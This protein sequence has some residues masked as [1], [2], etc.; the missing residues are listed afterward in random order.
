MRVHRCVFV[1]VYKC[2]LVCHVR[3]FACVIEIRTE[4]HATDMSFSRT[5]Y[6]FTRLLAIQL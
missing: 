3:V 5:S 2:M 1:D 4:Y 6:N